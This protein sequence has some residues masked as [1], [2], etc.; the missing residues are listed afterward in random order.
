MG[1]ATQNLQGKKMLS[2]SNKKKNKQKAERKMDII[3][4]EVSM[5]G[6]FC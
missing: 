2:V 3:R 1:M 6:K 5:L 4:L